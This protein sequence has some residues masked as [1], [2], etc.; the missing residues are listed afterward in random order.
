MDRRRGSLAANPLLIGALTTL[1]VSV[2]V[3]LSYNAL[4][5]LPF[6]PTY[7]IKVELNQANGL[8]HSNEVRIGGA[9][10]GLVDHIVA[11]QNPHTGRVSAIAYLKLEKGVEPLPANTKAIVQSVSALGLKYLLLEKGTSSQ[12]LKAGS[13]IPASNTREP[14]QI[15][16]L[17]KM[18]DQPTRMASQQNLNIFGDTFAGRGIGLNETIATLPSLL[19][20]AIP[21]LHNLASPQTNFHELW[22]AL[23]RTS[24]EVAPVAQS[25]ANL[26]SDLDTFFSA[27]A[28]VAPALEETI[29]GGG[30]ALRQAIH[31]LPFQAPFVEKTTEFFRLLRPSAKNLT[32]AAAPLG[33]AFEVG[34]TN[35]KAA[36][37]LN[38]QLAEA[39]K[40]LQVFIA[41][42]VVTLGIED[43]TQTTVAGGPLVA[44]LAPAQTTC[45]YFTLFFRNI[46]SLF[47]QGTGV[48]TLA[49]VAVLFSP[50]GPNAE[51]GP[52]SAPANGGSEKVG[53]SPLVD[54]NHLHFNPYPYVAGPGQP[55]VCEAGNEKFIPFQ[56]VIGN[57]PGTT[58][59]TH[60]ETKRSQNL[61]GLE[62]PSS[63]LRDLGIQSSSS[64]GKKK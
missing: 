21:V 52:S 59:T 45:N 36:T 31:S 48:G 19:K 23:E 46:A 9:R 15:E 29:V 24:A 13:T 2:A 55:K 35:L 60:D 16:E 26:Y 28:S 53:V 38:T 17:F 12:T 25:Q 42:P 14:V 41:N 5:G 10:V 58:S 18:F 49:R 6:T 63:T 8:L 32:T 37:S 7:D 27:F 22:I 50:L 64:K 3:Y 33:H 44:G 47:S 11:H 43:L 54:N 39:A 56:T 34:A 51:G 40:T 62:Y 57:V 4:N 1:I 30:P 61:N 20:N